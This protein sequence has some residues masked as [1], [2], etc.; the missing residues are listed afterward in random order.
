MGKRNNKQTTNKRHDSSEQRHNNSIDSSI[1]RSCCWLARLENLLSGPIFEV[2]QMAAR[3]SRPLRLTGS[4]RLCWSNGGGGGGGIAS[5]LRA[6][7][8]LAF[9][10]GGSSG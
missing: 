8:L 2:F 10:V 1:G 9:A 3:E 6:K 5:R 4:S 7:S